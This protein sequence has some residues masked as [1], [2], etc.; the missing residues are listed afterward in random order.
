MPDN[1]LVIGLLE[2]ILQRDTDIA[3]TLITIEKIDERVL[4][5][6]VKLNA[7]MNTLNHVSGGEAILK[8][9]D[10]ERELGMV[11]NYPE[12]IKQRMS[13]PALI[14]KPEKISN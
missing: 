7:S 13:Q 11:E 5:N 2:K 12:E 10:I 8:K 6:L 4:L 14:N 9:E 1:D 3:K